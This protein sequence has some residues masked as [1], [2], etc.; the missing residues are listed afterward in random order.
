MRR[1]GIIFVLAATV[2]VV[3]LAACKDGSKTEDD[4]V[5]TVLS[6]DSDNSGTDGGDM[7]QGPPPVSGEPIETGS[8][9]K[10]TEIEP[11]SGDSPEPGETV[12]VHYTGWLEDGT[13]FDSSVGGQ[14]LS[15]PIGVGRV[16]AGWD[17][18]LA[19]MQVGGKRR[20]IIPPELAYGPEGRPPVIP[21]NATLIFDVELLEIR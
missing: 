18:G 12:V 9:L 4:A 21:P 2:L 16:I 3:A 7:T 14:P 5:S 11:G 19:T 15:I 20:L 8:G 13:Q 10:Y 17:Q 1:K 6:E